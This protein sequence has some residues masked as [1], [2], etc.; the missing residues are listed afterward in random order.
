MSNLFDKVTGTT[1]S[2]DSSGVTDSSASFTVDYYTGWYV[3]I[4]SVEYLITSNT[5]TTLV[6]ANS[7]AANA[8]YSI[9]IVGR[10]FLTKIESDGA[11][12]TKIPDALIEKKYDQV[13]TDIQNKIFAYLRGYYTTT[14]DPLAN[15]LN[16]LVMQ[17]SFAYS[18]LAKIYQDLMIDQDSFESFKGYNMYN[19][20][21]IEAVKDAISLLQVDFDEDGTVDA[22]E[23]TQSA[24]AY[25]FLAR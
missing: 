8:D 14:F 24:A 13:N 18:V 25:T 19:K 3:T 16:P 7:I 6:F 23:K 2:F 12:T 4:D 21:Y 1:T 5:A 11:N 9:A 22:S 10:T 15:I 17:Q 20:D